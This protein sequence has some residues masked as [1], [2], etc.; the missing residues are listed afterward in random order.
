MSMPLVLNRNELIRPPPVTIAFFL[1]IKPSPVFV[2]DGRAANPS[3]V[4]GILPPPPARFLTNPGSSVQTLYNTMPPPSG[5]RTTSVADRE[6]GS[7]LRRRGP[8]GS[9]SI[10][11][12]RIAVEADA[13]PITEYYLEDA[14]EMTGAHGERGWRWGAGMHMDNSDPVGF[15]RPQVNYPTDGSTVNCS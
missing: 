4:P 6:G 13:P 10:S 2:P 3:P 15:P 12:A 7:R 11:V 8:T 1:L 5:G 14:L 9:V